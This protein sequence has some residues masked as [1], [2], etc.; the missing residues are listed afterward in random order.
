[1]QATPD[2]HGAGAFELDF[3]DCTCPHCRAP[4]SF[5]RPQAGTVQQCPQCAESV[6]VPARGEAVGGRLPLPI[7]T[8]R[9]RLRALRDGDEEDLVEVL[10]GPGVASDDDKNDTQDLVQREKQIRLGM[11]G[12]GLTLGVEL[13][14][15]GKLIG[16]VWLFF[17][18]AEHRQ[19]EFSASLREAYPLEDYGVEMVRGVLG[20][21]FGGLNLH[22]A[23][24]ST[25]SRLAATIDL[26]VKAGMRCEGEFLK[27]QFIR[28]EWVTTVWHGM[29][30]EE[31]K[32]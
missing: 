4:L 10:H 7:A 18:D 11:P 19:A 28:G 12:R 14:E 15:S 22:R 32:A 8:P 1:M 31:F 23:V 20:F 25:D 27:D 2:P 21:C 30:E 6:I 13:V 9:L 29:L 16:H 26:L 24:T 3:L 17:R 5:V